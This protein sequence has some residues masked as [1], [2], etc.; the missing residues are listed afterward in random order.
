[1]K[2]IIVFAF[3]SLPLFAIAQFNNGDVFIGGA[4][5]V[6]LQNTSAPTTANPGYTSQINSFSISPAIGF[7]L[8]QK[9][10]IGGDLSYGGS[11]QK[12]EN[13]SNNIQ[14][15]TK[16]NALGVGAIA[17]YYFPISNS[18]YFSLQ[19][20]IS[21]NRGT[22]KSDQTSGGFTSNSE[23]NNYSLGVNFN[24]VLIFFPS[25]QWGIEA[26]VGSFGYSYY[27][28]LPDVSHSSS[29][30]LSAGRFTFGLAYYFLKK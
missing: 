18:F 17:R 9:F 29:F 3:I 15:T 19:G 11:I 22:N 2:K 16:Y 13:P 6:S 30:N 23:S 7:F 21:F 14:S 1:M 4:A 27:R 12:Y 10:S 20:L 26:S 5:S 28:N 25:P 8:N 24:P